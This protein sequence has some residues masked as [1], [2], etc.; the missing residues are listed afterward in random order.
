M[1]A[2]DHTTPEIQHFKRLQ[3]PSQARANR[4]RVFELLKGKPL[5]EDEVHTLLF[6]TASYSDSNFE[7]ILEAVLLRREILPSAPEQGKLL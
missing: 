6:A 1:S 4:I 3:K 7:A 2:T 5:V